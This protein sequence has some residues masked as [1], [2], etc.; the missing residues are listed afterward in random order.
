MQLVG[1]KVG[2]TVEPMAADS[3]GSW[4]GMLA[5]CLVGQKAP[6]RVVRKAGQMVRSWVGWM[7]GL[8]E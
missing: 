5:L 6:M 8:R 7:A 3:V 2:R 1:R 4:A